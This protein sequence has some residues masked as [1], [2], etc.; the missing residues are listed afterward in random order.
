[1]IV[2]KDRLFTIIKMSF[3]LRKTVDLE[4]FSGDIFTKNFGDKFL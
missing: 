2:K 1:M 3:I 4:I